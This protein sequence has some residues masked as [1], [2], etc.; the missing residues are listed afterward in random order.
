MGIIDSG[1][2]SYKVCPNLNFEALAKG[3]VMGIFLNLTLSKNSFSPFNTFFFFTSYL[4]YKFNISLFYW[5]LQI[6]NNP[7]VAITL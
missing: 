5:C 6:S 2:D 4:L 7:R 3:F 1:T